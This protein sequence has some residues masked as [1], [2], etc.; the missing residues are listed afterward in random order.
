MSHIIP[1]A[2]GKGGVGKSML[3]ANLGLALAAQGLKVLLVDLDLGSSNLHSFLKV[4]NTNVGIGGYYFKNAAALEELKVDTEWPGLQIITGDTL[5][6]GTANIPWFFKKKVIRELEGLDEDIILVDLGAGTA[7]NT[8]D[9]FLSGREGILVTTPEPTSII[10]G[11]SFLKNLFFR[12]LHQLFSPKSRER[13]IIKEWSMQRNEHKGGFLGLL[14]ELNGAHAESGVRAS[15]VIQAL[16]PMILLN[17]YH[18]EQE[19][20]ASNSLISVTR[21]NLGL[22]LSLLGTVPHDESIRMTVFQRDPA[23]YSMPDSPFSRT[24][25]QISAGLLEFLRSNGS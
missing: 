7:F 25:K 1:L 15:Q 17:D 4:S 11:Y 23:F 14:E 22:N 19:S 13:D 9:F 8:V 2:S 12:V 18:T 21:E 10:N 20:G 3:T 16:R 5:F 6:P 24:M